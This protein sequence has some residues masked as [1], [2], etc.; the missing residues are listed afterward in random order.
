MLYQLTASEWRTLRRLHLAG[1]KATWEEIRPFSR[2]AIVAHVQA[3]L[4]WLRLMEMDGHVCQVTEQGKTVQELGELN[5]A[6]R[7]L[8]NR[9]KRCETLTD[10]SVRTK[11]HAGVFFGQSEGCSLA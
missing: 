3:V 11:K 1:G 10:T 7:E 8:R 6:T 2:R 9:P 5:I 4:L